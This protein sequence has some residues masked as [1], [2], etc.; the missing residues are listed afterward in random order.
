MP[1]PILPTPE[2]FPIPGISP[3]SVKAV[4][5]GDIVASEIGL[6]NLAADVSNK[7]LITSTITILWKNSGEFICNI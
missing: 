4:K 7:W 6:E 5:T 2:P 3:K 1:E